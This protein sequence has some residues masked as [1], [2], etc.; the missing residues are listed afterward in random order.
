MTEPIEQYDIL[1]Q[2]AR[3]QEQNEAAIEAMTKMSAKVFKGLVR[4]GLTREEALQMTQ[5]II[6]SFITNAG[7]AGN[8]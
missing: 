3:Q 6:G 4:G 8:D 1:T 2:L 7:K 5:H